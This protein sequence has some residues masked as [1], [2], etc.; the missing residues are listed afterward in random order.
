MIFPLINSMLIFFFTF[1]YVVRNL[2]FICISHLFLLTC[3]DILVL[4]GRRKCRLVRFLTKMC[5]FSVPYTVGGHLPFQPGYIIYYLVKSPLSLSQSPR[6][7]L[8]FLQS[9]R[10]LQNNSAKERAWKPA[11]NPFSNIEDNLKRWR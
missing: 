9:L 6:T 5:E 8:I 1:S 11:R 2:K 7:R 4:S 10:R 3:H